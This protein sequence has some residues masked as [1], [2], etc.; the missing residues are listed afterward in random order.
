M[1]PTATRPRPPASKPAERR[2]IDP[3]I[4]A[5]RAA[6]TREQGRRRLRVLMAGLAGTAL[7]V[8]VWMVLFHTP[9]FAARAITVVGAVHETPA[10]VISAGGLAT[11]P[12]LLDV[13]GGAV[14]TSIEKL[15]WVRSASVS[16]HWP[17]GVRVVVH[18]EVPRLAMQIANGQWAAVATDGRVLALSAARP[19]GLLTF[20]GPNVPTLT[21][22]TLGA[23]DAVGLAVASTLPPS[24]AAQVTGVTVEPA[25]W[26]QLAMTTPILVDI[27]NATEL[28][29]KYEDVSALL[30]GATLHTCDV[31]DVS[32]PQ[33][34]TV[35][36][37]CP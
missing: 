34:P 11:H 27:G 21:G 13:N 31:I 29:A 32:V 18:E 23:K 3:R 35:T 20:A 24:F 2:K 4:S 5:R 25:G 17:D 9:V 16:V 22:S 19:A 10:Q 26:V 1:S 8:G 15:P 36:K 28:S 12:P 6:V 30:A 33:A 7:L 14:A 37:G